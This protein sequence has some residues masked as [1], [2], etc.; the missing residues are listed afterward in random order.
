[1][2]SGVV[3]VVVVVIDRTGAGGGGAETTCDSGWVAQPA[4][5]PSA[6]QVIKAVVSR[7]I[8]LARVKQ[9]RIVVSFIFIFTEYF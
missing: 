4:R 5:R 3:V 7:A 9:G 6:P 8:L 1:M 2:V